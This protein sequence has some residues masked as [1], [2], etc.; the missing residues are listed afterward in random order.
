MTR[1]Q[2]KYKQEKLLFA[3]DASQL[4]ACL[5]V[6]N[7]ARK[8]TLNEL[9]DICCQVYG[10]DVK[11]DRL[12]YAI[13]ELDPECDDELSRAPP[14]VVEVIT[15]EQAIQMLKQWKS[16]LVKFESQ[17]VKSGRLN[18]EPT[19]AELQEMKSQF[20]RDTN[21]QDADLAFLAF[22]R[23]GLDYRALTDEDRCSN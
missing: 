14:P 2:L 17:V 6:A 18:S 5:R 8:N 12:I 11:R 19:S 21:G 10:A 7:T 9:V 1:C 16:L 3:D 13:D 20:F 15:R 23:Y 22:D 4:E